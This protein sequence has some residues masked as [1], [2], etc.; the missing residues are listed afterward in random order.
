[1][2]RPGSAGHNAL[3]DEVREYLTGALNLIEPW[4]EQVR[5]RQPSDDATEPASCAVC[6]LC[7]VITVLR[8]ERSELAVRM[9]E[10]AA[11]LVSVLRMAMAEGA[12]TGSGNTGAASTDPADERRAVQRIQVSRGDEPDD[13]PFGEVRDRAAGR[14]APW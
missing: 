10:Q 8:G 4:I 1:M 14:D 11:G 7:A 2:S 5:D 9:A 3:A 6:P 12:G 13:D